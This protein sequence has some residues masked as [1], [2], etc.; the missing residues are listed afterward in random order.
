[1]IEEHLIPVCLPPD[2]VQRRIRLLGRELFR[3][4]GLFGALH[5]PPL[6]AAAPAWPGAL[7]APKELCRE[8]LG[9]PWR[10]GG[11]VSAGGSLYLAVTPEQ[12]W[13]DFLRPGKSPY[14]GG[15]AAPAGFYCGPYSG[16]P[17]LPAP[18]LA[19]DG[20]VLEMRRFLSETGEGE[21]YRKWESFPVWSI[22][23]RP[24]S[25]QRP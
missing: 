7:N 17:P 9:G 15:E 12:G 20:V 19:W 4:C 23:P 25:G 22:K 5:E 11:W 8:E 3:S 10:T 14:G 24:R 2:G 13:P 1:M 18:E 6:F 21:S 16:P